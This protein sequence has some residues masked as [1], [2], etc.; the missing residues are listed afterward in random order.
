M[1]LSDVGWQPEPAL[2]PGAKGA[3]CLIQAFGRDW[4]GG[5]SRR[6]WAVNRSDEQRHRSA[7]FDD[8]QEWLMMV[9]SI[10]IWLVAYQPGMELNDKI[11]QEWLVVPLIVN[12]G[13]NGW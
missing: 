5:E 3:W 4:A 2:E 1:M 11:N 8:K 10:A 6:P 7:A 13:Q 9:N 12:D